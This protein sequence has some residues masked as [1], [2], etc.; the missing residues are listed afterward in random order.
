MEG[1]STIWQLWSCAAHRNVLPFDT[2]ATERPSGSSHTN[3]NAAQ[4]SHTHSPWGAA[5]LHKVTQQSNAVLPSHWRLFLECERN[6][7]KSFS[8]PRPTARLLGKSSLYTVQ[9]LHSPVSTQRRHNLTSHEFTA[10]RPAPRQV[11]RRARARSSRRPH[12]HDRGMGSVPA[13]L[14]PL[15]LRWRSSPQRPIPNTF[16]P[17]QPLIHTQLRIE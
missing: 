12:R 4:C 7:S 5:L 9:S 15:A 1:R 11:C 6:K 17:S 16:H 10:A 2:H 3:K 8:Q 14:R 13:R